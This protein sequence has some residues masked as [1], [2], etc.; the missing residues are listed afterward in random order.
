MPFCRSGKG[1]PD[2]D[3]DLRS[4]IRGSLTRA[5]PSRTTSRSTPRPTSLPR[6]A[7]RAEWFLR[8]ST[9]AG[10][11]EA[12]DAQRDV[13]GFR[14]EVLHPG[15]QRATIGRAISAISSGRS[16]A[17]TRPSGCGPKLARLA[18][19]CCLSGATG[20]RPTR[21]RPAR[22]PRT[23]A[24][25]WPDAGCRSRRGPRCTWAGARWNDAELV[26]QTSTVP[27]ASPFLSEGRR[28][29]WARLRWQQM[30]TTTALW[31]RSCWLRHGPS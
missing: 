24:M 20:W 7:R 12:A 19:S 5:S 10:E 4:L 13:R 17:A 14:G 26:D 15:G 18:T 9:V 30:R 23:D 2:R 21:A 6:S 8:F 28:T 22:P 27:A 1:T 31:A 16:S 25:G 3:H 29:V 11:R